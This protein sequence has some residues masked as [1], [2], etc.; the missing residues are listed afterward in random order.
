MYKYRVLL[1]EPSADESDLKTRRYISPQRYVI[2]DDDDVIIGAIL[3][4][5]RIYS[6]KWN[7]S[8]MILGTYPWYS[9]Y[10]DYDNDVDLLLDFPELIMK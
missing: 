1:R 3:I 8:R 6:T 10:K 7:G 4:P 9:L 5:D 2:T